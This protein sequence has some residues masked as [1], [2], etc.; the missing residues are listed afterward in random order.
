[1]AEPI[2]ITINDV[3][4]DLASC[5]SIDIRIAQDESGDENPN[6]GFELV[7]CIKGTPAPKLFRFA[8]KDQAVAQKNELLQ[9]LRSHGHE[10]LSF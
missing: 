8:S 5:T 9:L 10:I 1:M 6:L 3:F 7:I 4:L 2:F